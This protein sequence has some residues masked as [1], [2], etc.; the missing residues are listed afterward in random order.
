MLLAAKWMPL[1]LKFVQVIDI[2]EGMRKFATRYQF[3]L[4]DSD[5]RRM[6]EY[7][8]SAIRD[9][10][11]REQNAEKRGVTRT[12]EQVIRNALNRDLSK[13]SIYA[14]IDA[15]RSDVDNIIAKIRTEN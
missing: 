12:Y 9:Q 3:S 13:E 1:S 6:Y 4:S 11:S 2:T 14:L 8:L 7:E 15:P 10:Q 5:M